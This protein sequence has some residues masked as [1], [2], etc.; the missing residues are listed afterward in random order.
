MTSLSD[1]NG[2][3]KRRARLAL[4][5]GNVP[6]PSSPGCEYR[7]V[8]FASELEA[9]WATFFDALHVRWDYQPK[10]YPPQGV[11]FDDIEPLPQ[12]WLAFEMNAQAAYNEGTPRERGL[13]VGVSAAPPDAETEARYRLMAQRSHHWTH[14][15]VGEP[16]DGFRAWSW[17]FSE[18][19]VHDGCHGVADLPL[20][21]FAQEYPPAY[22]SAFDVDFIFNTV[23]NGACALGRAFELATLSASRR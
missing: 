19:Y 16:A 10:I 11:S 2:G 3:R 5:Q 14:L 9:H 21:E 7:F 6:S 12:F 17:R 23:G 15:L 1:R 18:R 13:W 4:V 8:R 20:R 22:G